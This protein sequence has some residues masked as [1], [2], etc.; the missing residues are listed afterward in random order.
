MQSI[1][2]QLTRLNSDGVTLCVNELL[3]YQQ[4][5]SLIDLSPKKMPQAKLSGSYLTKHKGRG[6]EFDE[7]RHY[8]PGDDIRAIDWRVT[9]RTG[10][11]HTKVY[12][13]ER[14]RP[15]FI[16]AD[17][18]S[19]MR[20]GTQLLTKSVQAAHT[21]ALLSW[22]GAMRGDK[23]GALI[24]NDERHRECRPMS[25]RRAVLAICHEMLNVHNATLADNPTNTNQTGL[26]DALVRAR[27]L[28]RPGS[29]VYVISDFLRFDSTSHQHLSQ[30]ARRCEVRGMMIN[31]PLEHS[32]PQSTLLQPVDVTDGVNRQQ[33]LIGDKAQSESY[34]KWR[35]SFY[36][37]IS[38]TLLKS[39]VTLTHIDA[40]IALDEQVKTMRIV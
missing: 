31:D 4:L 26:N 12:R 30:L 24:Y 32:L 23:V 22:A 19:S 5:A 21:A 11:T 7:A 34:R 14:E 36:D 38:A 40:G 25:R 1:Q 18:S 8:Q 29:L 9:A 3:R 13:E 28:A 17:F 35:E 33:W 10:K 20:F 27:R 15:V 37:E 39:G 16:I 2:A 6:M